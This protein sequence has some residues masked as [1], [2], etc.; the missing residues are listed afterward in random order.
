MIV[1]DVTYEA[2]WILFSEL[3][4]RRCGI[5]ATFVDISDISSVRN[6]VRP[7]HEI[8]PRRNDSQSDYKVADAE[9]IGEV[10]H[11]VVHVGKAGR[12]G[13]E[14]CP[15]VFRE[16]GHLRLSI[17]LEDPS[18]LVADIQAALDGTFA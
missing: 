16:Y 9:A 10:A 4:P 15:K 3:L 17:G 18:D 7:E 2:R 5:E 12:G 14:H 8:D 1:S 13:S 11:E 6:A